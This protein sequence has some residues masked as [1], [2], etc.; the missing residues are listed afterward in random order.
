[1]DDVAVI[2]DMATLAVGLGSAAAQRQNRG[3]AEEAF[4]T[5]IGSLLS[6]RM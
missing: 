2:D 1:M 4:E 6:F 5:A 3:R